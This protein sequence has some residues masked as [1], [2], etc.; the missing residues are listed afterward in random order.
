M[1]FADE[2]AEYYKE[3]P[4][5]PYFKATTASIGVIWD[6]LSEDQQHEFITRYFINSAGSMMQV[7]HHASELFSDLD[8]K[9]A[10]LNLAVGIGEKT[11]EAKDYV[12]ELEE[13]RMNQHFHQTGTSGDCS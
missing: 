9:L 13:A 5:E 6:E 8:T 10:L 4:K 1:S 2:N 11:E 7:L 3:A 12:R